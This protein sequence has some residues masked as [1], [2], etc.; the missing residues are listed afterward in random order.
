LKHWYITTNKVEL[1]A[2]RKST[3]QIQDGG[4]RH[5]EN[6]IKLNNLVTFYP[7]FTKFCMEVKNN[8]V[9]EKVRKPEVEIEIQD[10]CRRHFEKIQNA[11]TREPFDQFCSNLKHRHIT[12]NI[13]EFY[14]NRKSP[15]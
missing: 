8:Q 13:F 10:G 3:A 1:Y 2:N 9:K 4:G 6:H 12:F 14:T 7:I 11:I 15:T 5:L